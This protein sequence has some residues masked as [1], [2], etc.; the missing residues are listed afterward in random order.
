MNEILQM[1][2]VAAADLGELRDRVVFTGGATIPLYVDDVP[3]SDFRATD[4]V[5][6]I[7]ETVSR[8]DFYR[9]E[10]QLRE[11]GWSQSAIEDWPICRW[12]TPSG[13]V[14]DVMPVDESILGFSNR[15]YR[16]GMDRTAAVSLPNQTQIS[17]LP[18]D[19][20]LSSKL[21]AFRGRGKSDWYVSHDLEDVFTVIEGR[22]DV[23]SEITDAPVL[24]KQ[25]LAAW[26]RELSSQ[27]GFHDVVEGHLAPAAVRAG[28]LDVVL[29]RVEA[30]LKLGS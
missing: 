27:R 14:V 20:F 22:L 16:H 8:L 19:V 13:G 18:I 5:D 12:R 29:E 2:V 10:K 21:D 7:V 30:I 17:I 24:T 15:W 11:L 25:Y 28:R 6:V 26:A 23:V 3:S 4:D 1:L 9:L